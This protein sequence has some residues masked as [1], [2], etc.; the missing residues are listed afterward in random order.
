MELHVS[1]GCAA[2]NGRYVESIPRLNEL[3]ASLLTIENGV[4]VAPA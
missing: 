4:T 1:R 3:T 2:P